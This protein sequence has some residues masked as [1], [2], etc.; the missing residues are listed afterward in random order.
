MTQWKIVR[1]FKAD[2]GAFLIAFALIAWA[3][4]AKSTSE[5]ISLLVLA[6]LYINDVDRAERDSPQHSEGR[7]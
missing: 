4:T 3:I 7:K 5:A 2:T 6:K 1:Q